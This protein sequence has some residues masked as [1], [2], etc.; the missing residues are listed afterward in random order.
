VETT[1]EGFQEIKKLV[2]NPCIRCGKQRIE[3]NSC[4]KKE[5]SFLVT[6]TK[7]VC[8]DPECQKLVD[9]ELAKEKSKRKKIKEESIKR[10]SERIKRIQVSR[11]KKK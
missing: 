8:P 2:N 9:K 3:L 5:G 4:Q 1:G 7:T 6:Y 10:E 11:S